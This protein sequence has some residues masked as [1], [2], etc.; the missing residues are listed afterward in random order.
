MPKYR[1]GAHRRQTGLTVIP[2]QR[3]RLGI[4][5]SQPVWTAGPRALR[6]T[7]AVRARPPFPE[8]P[9]DWLGSV[10]EWAIYWAATHHK[11][12]Q[13]DA[14]FTYQ[15]AYFGGR[16]Q[17]GGAV[18]DFVF[19]G[20]GVAVNVNGIFYHLEQGGSR[21]QALDLAQGDAL[22]RFGLALIYI[23]DDAALR[24]PYYYLDEALVGRD[25]SILRRG[26]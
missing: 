16:L 1:S 19:P 22:A 9:G 7:L 17:F 6:G 20:F 21:Q 24:D 4:T 18:L 23:D 26:R 11:K 5:K 15:A 10:P 25:H 12:L 8:P 13:P 2:Q 14:D 3:V